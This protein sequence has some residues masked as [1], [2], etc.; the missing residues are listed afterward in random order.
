MQ[1]PTD[2]FPIFA[3]MP[4]QFEPGESRRYSNA[5]FIVRGAIVEAASGKQSPIVS[6]Y[7][8]VTPDRSRHLRP[9]NKI[10]RMGWFKGDF[11]LTGCAASGG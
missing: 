4:L 10:P 11:R 8:A 7:T 2:F 1:S 3:D 6:I 5:G 9:R